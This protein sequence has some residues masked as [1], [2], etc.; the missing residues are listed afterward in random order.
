[1][2]NCKWFFIFVLECNICNLP[3]LSVAGS[4]PKKNEMPV[5]AKGSNRRQSIL[6]EE[7]VDDFLNNE[8]VTDESLGCK[9]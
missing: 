7:T 5:A 1:M 3:S 2:C 9:V 6:H 8:A 4:R